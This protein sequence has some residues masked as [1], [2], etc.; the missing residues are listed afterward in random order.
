MLFSL[1]YIT[2]MLGNTNPVRI[3]QMLLHAFGLQGRVALRALGG[4]RPP[5]QGLTMPYDSMHF[6]DRESKSD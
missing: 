1:S 2:I 4:T 6:H 5:C 3:M